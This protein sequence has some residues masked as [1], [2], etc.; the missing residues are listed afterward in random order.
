MSLQEQDGPKANEQKGNQDG[1]VLIGAPLV[2]KAWEGIRI[3]Q[4]RVS[5]KF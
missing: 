3:F 5:S 2:C 4:A 1:P